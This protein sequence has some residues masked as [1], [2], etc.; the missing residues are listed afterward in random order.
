MFGG[1]PERLNGEVTQLAPAEF[2]VKVSR[3][4]ILASLSGFQQMWISKADYDEA[5]A[6]IVHLKCT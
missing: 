3:G 5:G 6:S 2:T 1:L 4:S